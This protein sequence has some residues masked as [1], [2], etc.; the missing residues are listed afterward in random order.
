M[1]SGADCRTN[2]RADA[3]DNALAD[4]RA[5]RMRLLELGRLGRLHG[6]VRQWPAYA[7]SHSHQR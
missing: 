1:H 7:L 5:R 3:A 4:T 6:G 2:G